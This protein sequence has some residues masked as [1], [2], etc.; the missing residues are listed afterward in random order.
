MRFVRFASAAVLAAAAAS[1]AFASPSDK[2]PEQHWFA[3][4]VIVFRPTANMAGSQEVWPADPELPNVEQAIVPAAPEAAAQPAAGMTTFALPATA[5]PPTVAAT[6]PADLVL[7][8]PSNQYQMQGILNRL[9]Q[10]GRY[11]TLIHTGWIQQGLPRGKAPKVSITPLVTPTP[12]STNLPTVAT[13]YSDTAL[14]PLPT[15]S[16]QPVQTEVVKEA[17]KTA[18]PTAPAFGTIKMSFDRFLHL[19]LDIAYRPVNPAVLQTWHSTTG[20]FAQPSTANAAPAPIM[21]FGPYYRPAPPEPQ[22]VVMNDSR[23]VDPNQVNYF[24][25]PLFGVI[26][27]VTPVEPPA[28]ALESHQ[29]HQARQ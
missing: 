19:A 20:E 15:T 28:A 14:A 4:E 26:V 7:P 6:P 27:Q 25:N 21:T 11:Q 9:E 29:R 8:L 12:A 13:I 23:S 24:D 18:P 2:K 22:A 3:V 1:A 17:K 5:T 16:Q 10:S